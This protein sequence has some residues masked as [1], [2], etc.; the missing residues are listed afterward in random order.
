M[1]DKIV[2]GAR[3]LPVILAQV[4]CSVPY[5]VCFGAD[6]VPFSGVFIFEVQCFMPGRVFDSIQQFVSLP[7]IAPEYCDFA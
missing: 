1:Q 2:S 3:V 6:I 4:L 7:D 5:R